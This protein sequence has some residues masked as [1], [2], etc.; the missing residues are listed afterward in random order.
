MLRGQ[1][2]YRIKYN[3]S[4]KPL[5]LFPSGTSLQWLSRC[6]QKKW[7]GDIRLNIYLYTPHDLLSYAISNS[8]KCFCEANQPFSMWASKEV[9]ARGRTGLETRYYPAGRRFRVAVEGLSLSQFDSELS[10]GV[11]LTS[12]NIDWRI[13][14]CCTCFLSFHYSFWEVLLCW[15]YIFH[16]LSEVQRRLGFG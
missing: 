6:T 16:F 14:M 12:F 13:C 2:G 4:G 10:F 11:H 8:L 9:W 7:L 1:I 5:V 15:S 3:A